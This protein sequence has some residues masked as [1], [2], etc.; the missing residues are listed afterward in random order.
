MEEQLKEAIK[1]IQGTITEQE[2]SDTELEEQVISIPADPHIKNFSFALVGEDIYYRE[3]SV[4]NKMEFPAVTGERIR[5]MV[6]IRDVTNRLLERQL[7]EC[8]DEEIAGL[9]AE[10]N[11][12]YDSFTEKYGL[13]SS[14]AS[15]TKAYL[16]ANGQEFCYFLKLVWELNPEMEVI[17]EDDNYHIDTIQNAEHQKQAL[18][19][20]S[21]DF[22][23][24][25]INAYEEW[26]KKVRAG[27]EAAGGK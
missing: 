10:L 24:L 4:M 22:I 14:N 21:D 1:H 19:K 16:A 18:K 3:N 25:D 2:I 12:V 15:Q 20:M 27:I 26:K 7:E 5:G 23:R 6:A 17:T 8:S 13:L 9:Q 11:H